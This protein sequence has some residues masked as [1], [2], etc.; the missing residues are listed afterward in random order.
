MREK[1][2]SWLLIGAFVLILG[3]S[4]YIAFGVNPGD[5]PWTAFGLVYGVFSLVHAYRLLGTRRALTLLA[6]ALIVGFFF[7]A[8]GVA[9][10]W[11]FGDY[12]YTD[13]LPYHVLG[14]PIIIPVYWFIVA[15][16]AYVIT[17]VLADGETFAIA[18]GF[19]WLVLISGLNALVMT[20]WDLS[21]DPLMSCAWEGAQNDG[22]DPVWS[23]VAAGQGGPVPVRNYL[24]WMLATFVLF[25]VYRALEPRTQPQ[26]APMYRWLTLVIILTYGAQAVLF[27]LIVPP[28][29]VRL[30]T[31]FVMGIPVLATVLEILRFELGGT[32]RTQTV[33]RAGHQ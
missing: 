5:L 14:V 6:T 21:V 30:L 1:G 16:P 12:H 26:K 2:L 19:K 23:W 22:C 10:G 28:A 3:V 29:D 11:P 24:G 9:T 31:P 33:S 7:E 17:N 20:G 27:A 18:S 13:E 4:G 32:L 15:Y 25:V 8:V